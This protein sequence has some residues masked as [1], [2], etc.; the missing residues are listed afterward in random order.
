VNGS[1]VNVLNQTEINDL[2]SLIDS[3]ISKNYHIR[4]FN[5]VVQ[6]KHPSSGINVTSDK[7]PTLLGQK[8]NYSATVYPLSQTTIAP[9]GYVKFTIDGKDEPILALD[10]GGKATLTILNLPIG[11][12]MLLYNI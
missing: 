5:Q 1:Q 9:S 11:S 2:D 12:H 10:A 8:V 7:N 4:T 6:F 3:I